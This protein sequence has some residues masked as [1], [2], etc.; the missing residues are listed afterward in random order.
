MQNS[1]IFAAAALLIAAVSCQKIEVTQ[2][3]PI[4]VDF[5]AESIET[6][7]AFGDKVDGVYPTLWTDNDSQVKIAL[8][9]DNSTQAKVTPDSGYTSASFSAS[10]TDPGT[11]S[12][13]FQA[14]SPASAVLAVSPTYSSFTINIPTS[15]TPTPASVDEAAQILAAKSASSSEFPTTV[16]FSFQHVTAYG[17]MNL[18]NLA[19]GDATITSVSLTASSAWAGR[20]YYYPEEGRVGANSASKTITINTSSTTD[21][22]FACAPVDLGGGT[23]TLTVNT[24]AGPFTKQI[25]WPSGKAFVSGKVFKFNVD[26]AGITAA[27]TKTYTK[28]TDVSELS[29]GSSVIIVADNCSKAL[30]TTQNSNNRG[31]AAI[32]KSGDSILDPGPDVQVLQV[33][34]GY[35][36]NTI[37]FYDS[38]RSGYLYGGEGSNNYLRTDASLNASASFAV[39]IADGV[40]TITSQGSFSRQIMYNSGSDLFGCYSSGQQTVSIYKLEGAV[41]PDP[42]PDPDPSSTGGWLE[43]P[44]VTGSE[45]FVGHFGSGTS[46]NY[47]Y[48]YDYTRYASLW[49][50]YPLCSAHTSGSASTSN[51]AYNPDIDQSLQV[52][53]LSYSYGKQYGESSYAR[54]HQ[55]PNADR[56]C[57]DT[58]NRQTYYAT[59]QTPQLQNKFNASVWSSLENSVRGLLSSTDTIYVATGPVYQTVG[60]DES[61]TYLTGITATSNPISL[62]VPNYYWKVLLKVKRTAGVVTSASAVGV[63]LPH[64]EYSG[65]TWASYVVS[66]DEIESKTGLDLFTNLPDTVESTAEANS[67]WSAFSAF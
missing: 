14:I 36:S 35:V 4:E 21:L 53:I 43:L 61:I 34:T 27:E 20:W 47:S 5:I 26:M 42:D 45:D 39:S 44:A 23:V 62:P 60:G 64:Q 10:F 28:V 32:T 29:A 15:Q 31:V 6:K 40:T 63:W 52:N 11:G 9:Y 66:V 33:R 38:S 30:S 22:W 3:V 16:P 2:V 49:T 48:Y 12:Y 24:T 50:A 18:V 46:R 65:S 37:A 54:G 8:N 1:R 51:W 59:N 41:T 57:D 67:S 25:S 55:I 13:A 56:R 58:M 17:R 7:T 19:L